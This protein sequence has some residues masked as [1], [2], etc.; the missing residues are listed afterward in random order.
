MS[1]ARFRS[2]GLGGSLSARPDRSARMPHGSEYA[3]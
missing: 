1:P 3:P 2:G